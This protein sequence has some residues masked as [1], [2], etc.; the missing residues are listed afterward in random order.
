MAFRRVFSST[1]KWRH[2]LQQRRGVQTDTMKETQIILGQNKKDLFNV[3]IF[4]LGSGIAGT[5]YYYVFKPTIW[6]KRQPSWGP[7]YV[8]QSEAKAKLNTTKYQG[9]TKTETEV[10]IKNSEIEFDEKTIRSHLSA[11]G[12]DEFDV[13]L[14]LQEKKSKN[15]KLKISEILDELIEK[16]N[17][18]ERKLTKDENKKI[19]ILKQKTMVIQKTRQEDSSNQSYIYVN[20]KH[21]TSSLI[22]GW[23]E[24]EVTLITQLEVRST[25]VDVMQEDDFVHNVYTGLF[26]LYAGLAC[27][28]A[29]KRRCLLRRDIF[30]SPVYFFFFFF[31]FDHFNLLEYLFPNSPSLLPPRASTS[32]LS[33]PFPFPFLSLPLPHFYFPPLHSLSSA[34]SPSFLSS[35]S[36]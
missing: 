25:I 18:N 9:R 29:F 8:D 23:E 32:S 30:L 28:Y 27:V 24:K 2:I 22:S 16:Y 21:E 14:I 34:L 4:L 31:S 3:G 5:M 1:S 15:Q 33:F 11:I 17:K 26:A 12:F 7:N 13:S 19:A 6:D 36:E 20:K 10:E 35:R